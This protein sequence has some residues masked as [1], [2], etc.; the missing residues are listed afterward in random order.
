MVPPVA[1]RHPDRFFRLVEV[2]P[3]TLS[4]IT[5][6]CFRLLADDHSGSAGRGVDLDDTKQL[7]A[8]LVVFK[9]HRGAVLP[10]RQARY[11]VRVR[12]KSS[13][14][15]QP[16]PGFDR[17][18]H[19]DLDVQHVSRLRI[20]H[21]R[22]LRLQLVLGRRLDEMHVTAIAGSHLIDSDR[23]RVRRPGERVRIVVT[24]FGA[25]GAEERNLPFAGFTDGHVVVVD[26]RVELS[27]G[28]PLRLGVVDLEWRT[29]RSR[30][31]ASATSSAAPGARRL[32]PACVGLE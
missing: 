2:L 19:R 15:L 26:Q 21:R 24:P 28:R 3:E 6:E 4:G 7:V 32:L 18:Q 23:L 1:L 29:N 14:D 17:E 27:V 10:P 12:E 25:V 8:A 11:V 13:I 20:L 5:E 9:Y 30:E 16:L 31:A 22:M